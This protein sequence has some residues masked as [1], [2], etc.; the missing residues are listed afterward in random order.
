MCSQGHESR[1]FSLNIIR[2]DIKMYPGATP[3]ALHLHVYTGH[4]PAQYP[5]FI[6]RAVWR[7][8]WSAERAAPKVGRGFK[9]AFGHVDENL[10]QSALMRHPRIIGAT[11]YI[12]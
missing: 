5:I 12:T 7:L 11:F 2:L 6:E 10:A 1:Y 4:H 9:I 8:F 3:D